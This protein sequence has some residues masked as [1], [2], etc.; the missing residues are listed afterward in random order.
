MKIP[1]KKKERNLR[2]LN[3]FCF[4]FFIIID[5]IA[6]AF[7]HELNVLLL[8]QTRVPDSTGSPEFDRKAKIQICFNS[9][10]FLSTI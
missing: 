2:I 4:K 6:C 7:Q 8:R 5:W 3:I 10:G 1:S 9:G